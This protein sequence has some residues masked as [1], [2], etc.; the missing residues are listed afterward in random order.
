MRL[1]RELIEKLD[2][3]E[4]QARK[5][6]R[7]EKAAKKFDVEALLSAFEQRRT[8]HLKGAAAR[9]RQ[10]A[11]IRNQIIQKYNYSSWPKRDRAGHIAEALGLSPQYVRRVVKKEIVK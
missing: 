10:G 11:K 5:A 1:V 3:P 6:R 9:K 2:P 4:E 8:L 7:A